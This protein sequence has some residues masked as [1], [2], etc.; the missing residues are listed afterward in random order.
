[1][2]SRAPQAR[3]ETTLTGLVD[4]GAVSGAA[5]RVNGTIT[6]VVDGNR[7]TIDL[8]WL[9]PGDLPKFTQDMQLTID[10]EKL[11]DGTLVA[12]NLTDTSD[13]KGTANQGI[14]G[15][16][17]TQ[18]I[19]T[20]DDSAVQPDP[21]QNSTTTTTAVATACLPGT[22]SQT[23]TFTSTGRT[24]TFTTT[25]VPTTTTTSLTTTT[26]VPTTVTSTANTTTTAT[27]SSTA[28]T[29]TTSTILGFNLVTTTTTST[30]TL[31][32]C[33]TTT[34]NTATT[35]ST[36]TTATVPVTQT[37]TTT[38][39]STLTNTNTSTATATTT[40]TTS[41]TTTA[42][43]TTTETTF[44][45]GVGWRPSDLWRVAFDGR[46][47]MQCAFRE[48]EPS[49]EADDRGGGPA[50]SPRLSPS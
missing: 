27:T 28:T 15:A 11:P 42:V 43:T 29:T 41:T 6:I 13:R 49:E 12:T 4:C 34:A 1:M 39:T 14:Q 22:I 3:A 33:V 36:S 8:S 20:G 40:A 50:A 19:T 44:D 35:T 38:A 37:T 32:D 2:L 21:T 9:K 46:V 47:A 16:K 7:Y 5:C 23:S 26:T 25:T 10:I 45:C 48:R 18:H 31:L 30:T 24:T 17:T